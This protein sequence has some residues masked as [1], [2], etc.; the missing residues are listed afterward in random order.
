MYLH[1]NEGIHRVRRFEYSN[2]LESYAG[3]IIGRYSYSL[4]FLYLRLP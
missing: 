1:L 4:Y 2:E 3:G